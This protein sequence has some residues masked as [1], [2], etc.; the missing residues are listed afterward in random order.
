MNELRINSIESFS[1]KDGDGIRSVVFLQGCNLRCDYCHNPETWDMKGGEAFSVADLADKV[2]RFKDYWGVDGGVTISGGEPLLQ[3]KAL[4][5]FI[6]F[7]KRHDVNVALDTSG[8]VI[9]DDVRDV[10]SL[11]DKIILDIKNPGELAFLDEAEK[12]C[13][14]VWIR[15]VIVPGVNDTVEAADK[16]AKVLKGRNVEKVELV[17]FH[18]LGFDKYEK[19]GIENP[20][21]NTK[22]CS[23]SVVKELQRRFD[24]I[25]K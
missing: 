6:E 21:V 22:G 5:G 14:R 19:L 20:L 13:K 15:I 24:S 18:T 2:L 10:I 3:A 11:C 23:V 16:Y 8:S 1:T 9:N 12:S 25:C 7:L 17:P 4:I